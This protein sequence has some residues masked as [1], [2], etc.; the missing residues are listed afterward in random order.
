MTPSNQTN[1]NQTGSEPTCAT[2]VAHLPPDM[3]LRPKKKQKSSVGEQPAATG[4]HG[5]VDTQQAA[6][7]AVYHASLA[8]PPDKLDFVRKDQQWPAIRTSTNTTAV[9]YDTP[10]KKGDWSTAKKASFPSCKPTARAASER[11]PHVDSSTAI[12]ASSS[13]QIGWCKVFK[14]RLCFFPT[15]PSGSDMSRCP[16]KSRTAIQWTPD[17]QF[18]PSIQSVLTK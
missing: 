5:C 17:P 18:S 9:N 12:S 7:D 16:S 4:S 2:D 8:L 14:S 13:A 10:R 3:P 1:C 6:A 11:G 15:E